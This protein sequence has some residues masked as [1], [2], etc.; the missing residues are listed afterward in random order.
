MDYRTDM[1]EDIGFPKDEEGDGEGEEPQVPYSY[2]KKFN[3][4]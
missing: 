3:F 2:F 1:M 4:E